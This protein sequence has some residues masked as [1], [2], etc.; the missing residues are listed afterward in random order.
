MEL[1]TDLG[2]LPRGVSN[3]A[4]APIWALKSTS[5]IRLTLIWFRDSLPKEPGDGNMDCRSFLVPSKHTGRYK[6]DACASIR[7]YTYRQKL[8]RFTIMMANASVSTFH[9]YPVLCKSISGWDQHLKIQCSLFDIRYSSSV[10]DPS[11]KISL[12][13]E[14]L[15]S[16]Y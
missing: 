11:R 1:N 4:L 9:D 14:R 7:E 10:L 5:I 16:V 15:K 8:K 6:R 3:P 13:R 12:R 2:W